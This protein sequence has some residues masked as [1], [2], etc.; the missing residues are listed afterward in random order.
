M[1]P[2]RPR[3]VTPFPAAEA[4]TGTR[5]A[6]SGVRRA[7]RRQP[8]SICAIVFGAGADRLIPAAARSGWSAIECKNPVEVLDHADGATAIVLA[9]SEAELRD[10]QDTVS[11]LR[12]SGFEKPIVFAIEAGTQRDLGPDP[13]AVEARTRGASAAVSQALSPEHILYH[14]TFLLP[15]EVQTALRKSTPPADASPASLRHGRLRVV[16]RCAYL[17]KRRI[18]LD[19]SEL[20][21]L[22]FLLENRGRTVSRLEFQKRTGLSLGDSA[23]RTRISNLRDKLGDK[24]ETLIRSAGKG[25]Y[26]IGI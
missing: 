14:A 12:N 21:T 2:P 7:T 13:R 22:I 18:P 5:R 25:Y 11:A 8:G 9:P 17:G 20:D 24:D 23:F 1:T 16:N 10:A 4:S 15:D 26:G 6:P 19:R 3:N